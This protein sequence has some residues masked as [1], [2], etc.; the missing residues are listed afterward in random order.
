MITLNEIPTYKV[1]IA[2]LSEEFENESDIVKRA[3]PEINKIGP[4][5][6]GDFLARDTIIMLGHLYSNGLI[7]RELRA[8]KKGYDDSIFYDFYYR[9]IPNIK[10]VLLENQQYALWD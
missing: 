3:T 2:Q 6:C 8:R 4:F 10:P 7:G 5:E 1:L 9:S